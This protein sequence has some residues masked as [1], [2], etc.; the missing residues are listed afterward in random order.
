[1]I[2]I[3]CIVLAIFCFVMV[4]KMGKNDRNRLEYFKKTNTDLYNKYKDAFDSYPSDYSGVKLTVEMVESRLL[5]GEVIHHSYS[6]P[7]FY[8]KDGNLFVL[9]D[10]RLIYAAFKLSKREI[11][12]IP[13][14][15]I[16]NID[17]TSK[18]IGADLKVKSKEEKVEIYFNK[19]HQQYLN[20]FYEMLTE[21]QLNQSSKAE[22]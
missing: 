18:T 14:N 10:K 19:F 4:G 6:L 1:M 20:N 3:I 17:I 12:S 16:E 2:I 21:K 13:Y 22:E 11:K 7:R 5:P 9:T 8:N 15:K